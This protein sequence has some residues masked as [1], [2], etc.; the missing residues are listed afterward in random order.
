MLMPA[1]QVFI[2]SNIWLYAFVYDG[3]SKHLKA[4]HA[5]ECDNIVISSQVISEVC[6]NLIRKANQKEPF[7][8]ELILDL[9]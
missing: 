2:D 7:I 8:R 4:K 3:T 1:K 9:Y 6:I 5:I